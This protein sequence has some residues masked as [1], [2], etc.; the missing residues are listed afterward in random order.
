MENQTHA[1]I[2]EGL[3]RDCHAGACLA[4]GFWG[5]RGPNSDR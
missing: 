5:E 3:G 1:G 4:R 2:V